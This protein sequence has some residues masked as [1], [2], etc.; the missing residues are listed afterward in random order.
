MRKTILA[1]TIAAALAGSA[2]AQAADL[3]DIYQLAV[4]NDPT[5]LQADANY[6]AAVENKPIARAGYLPN[7]TL[8]G[9]R[10]ITRSS[11][12]ESRSPVHPSRISTSARTTTTPPIPRS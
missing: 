1:V 11:G 9:K 4:Q 3:W 5:F 2:Q 12:P 6:Q 8:N 10:T 7:I